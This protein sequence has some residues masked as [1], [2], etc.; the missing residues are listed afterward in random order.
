MNIHMA[1]IYHLLLQV[2]HILEF[3]RNWSN[4]GGMDMV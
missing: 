2:E 4:G 3:D 1:A